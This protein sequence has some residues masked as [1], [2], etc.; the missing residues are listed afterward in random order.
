MIQHVDTEQPDRSIVITDLDLAA[1]AEGFLS[2]QRRA[3]VDSVLSRCPELRSL[4]GHCDAVGQVCQDH[5]SAVHVD[6][7]SQ[8][9]VVA[10]ASAATDRTDARGSRRNKVWWTRVASAALLC[11]VLIGGSALH[12][13]S[14]A[15]ARLDHVEQEI[16]TDQLVP[17]SEQSQAARRTLLEL[18][19]SLLLSSRDNRRRKRL[20]ATMYLADA[21]IKFDRINLG[22]LSGIASSDAVNLCV[23]VIDALTTQRILS[24][25]ERQLLV[26]AWWIKANV[27]FAFGTVHRGDHRANG[28]LR[29]AV[30]SL[31]SAAQICEDSTP[32]FANLYELK[33][34]GLL[35]KALH[36]GAATALTTDPEFHR[37]L[38]TSFPELNDVPAGQTVEV[39][40]RQAT[41]QQGNDPRFAVAFLNIQNTLALHLSQRPGRTSEAEET[42][43][44][45]LEAAASVDASNLPSAVGRELPLIHGR[46]FGN[47]ADLNDAES[48]L[49]SAARERD[50]AIGI[51]KNELRLQRN[52]E[53]FF[54]LG[55][56]TA[57]QVLTQYRRLQQGACD[58][59]AVVALIGSLDTLSGGFQSMDGFQL[60]PHEVFIL[61]VVRA[62]LSGATGPRPKFS[63]Y[64]NVTTSFA[65]SPRQVSLFLSFADHEWLQEDADF[66]AA[67]E[68]IASAQPK[69]AAL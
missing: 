50:S 68:A 61:N 5:E 59:G 57:R 16:L 3:E 20:L 56:V 11:V 63:D 46:L 52:N 28:R 7:F 51:F 60:A 31:L 44:R 41:H 45:A 19:D 37:N 12:T 36:K 53:L 34:R 32:D 38:R 64:V 47:L 33:I 2:P 55:W 49:D 66:Q 69:D 40:C 42:Y 14:A 9:T 23:R 67:V 22:E 26:E 29:S 54:E 27:E 4:V 17:G 35:A 1:Y 62:E 25:V 39:L 6:K 10:P 43:Q 24:N 65:V 18:G 15:V 48:D 21:R 30:D 58:E 8:H 13:A